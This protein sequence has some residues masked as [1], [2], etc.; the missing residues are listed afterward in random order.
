MLALHTDHHTIGRHEILDGVALLEEL[1]IRGHIELDVNTT[2]LQLVLD[3]LAHLSG[4]THRHRRLGD[5]HHILFEVLANGLRHL[6][7]IFQI[8]TA[9]FVGRCAYSREDNFDIIQHRSQVGGELQSSGCNIL[10]HQFV[11]AWLINRNDTFLQT[12]DFLGVD[13]NTNHIGT[14]ISKACT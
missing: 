14:C 9:V 1:R 13:I 10:L 3:G 7:H 6:Q 11:E 5:Y 2:L 8:C 12:L 4:S